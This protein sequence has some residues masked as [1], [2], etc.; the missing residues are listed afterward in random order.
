MINFESY[1]YFVNTYAIFVLIFLL[2]AMLF[3]KNQKILKFFVV[4]LILSFV[5]SVFLKELF[6][7]PR[8]FLTNLKEVS[9]GLTFSSS[10]PSTHST[11]LFSSA[12]FAKNYSKKAFYIFVFFA[13][14]LS[15]LR[16]SANAHSFLD[17]FGGMLIGISI[18]LFIDRWHSQ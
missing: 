1:F 6:L 18:A 7:I 4:A 5:F 9:G 11:L 16:I 14:I 10:F 15:L 8:P 12:V 3:F 2:A 17:I 13:I